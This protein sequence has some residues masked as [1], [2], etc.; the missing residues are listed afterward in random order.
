MEI[1]V[2]GWRAGAADCEAVKNLPAEQLPV[3]TD[4]QREVTRKLGIPELDDTRSALASRRSQETLLAKTERLAR[5]LSRMLERWGTQASVERV[6]LRTFDEKFDVVLR[7]TKRPCPSGSPN[8]WSMTFS[9]MA[10]R[11]GS[12]D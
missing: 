2:D 4:E 9:R 6:T 5:L 8:Q 7:M 3:L 10:P 1:V 11:R 12:S